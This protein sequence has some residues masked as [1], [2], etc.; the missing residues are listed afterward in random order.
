MIIIY[1]DNHPE[2]SAKVFFNDPIVYDFISNKKFNKDKSIIDFHHLDYRENLGELRESFYL[3]IS[4]YT[5]FI[6]N[7]CKDYLK[8]G[9]ILVANNS[10]GDTGMASIDTD[11]QFIGVLKKKKIFITYFLINIL[12]LTLFLKRR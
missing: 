1:F 9:G 12:I 3:L 11:Y 6:S 10:H 7:Y 8:V 4:Q 2:M 5:G